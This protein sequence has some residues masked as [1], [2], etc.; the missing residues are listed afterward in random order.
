[1]NQFSLGHIAQRCNNFFRA[2]TN[3]FTRLNCTIITQTTRHLY[4]LC[5]NTDGKIWVAGVDWY[6]FPTPQIGMVAFGRYLKVGMKGFYLE[7]LTANPPDWRRFASVYYGQNVSGFENYV[8][9][10]K[11]YEDK[12]RAMAAERGLTL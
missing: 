9:K 6:S 1:M 11:E 4:T 3:D 7:C 8:V 10:L 2:Q 12:Y 5:I